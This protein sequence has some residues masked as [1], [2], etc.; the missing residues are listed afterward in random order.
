[1]ASLAEPAA[2]LAEADTDS[3]HTAPEPPAAATVVTEAQ[4]GQFLGALRALGGS[5]GNMSLRSSLGWDEGTYNAVK[6][7]LVAAGTIVPGRGRGGSV[8]LS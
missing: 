6:D 1:M 2:A 8:T 7:S 5:A 4:R 3:E